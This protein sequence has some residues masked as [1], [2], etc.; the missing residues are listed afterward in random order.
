MEKYRLTREAQKD[1]DDFDRYYWSGYGC[2][3]HIFPP[4]SYCTH[5]GNPLC[6]ED[7]ECWE[8]IGDQLLLDFGEER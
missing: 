5:P 3:C 6:Q 1:R 7:D 4:C 8:K 2:T